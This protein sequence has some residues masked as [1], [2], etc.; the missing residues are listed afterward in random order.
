MLKEAELQK[1]IMKKIEDTKLLDLIVNKEIIYD[2]VDRRYKE[3][4]QPYFSINYLIREKYLDYGNMILKALDSELE[5]INGST[6]QNISIDDSE[7]LYP[8]II[9][10]NYNNNKYF[11]LELKRSSSAEREAVTEILGY[12][13]EIKNHLPFINNGDVPLIIVSTEFGDLLLHS[14]ASLLFD[15]I[16]V[17][18]LKPIINNDI[19]ENFMIMDVSAWTNLSVSSVDSMTFTGW[20][21]CLYGKDDKQISANEF[22]NDAIIAVDYL[23]NDANRIGSHGFC[24]VWESLDATGVCCTQQT[25]YFISVFT[26]NPYSIFYNDFNGE[27]QKDILSK[28][29]Y[30]TIEKTDSR[31]SPTYSNKMFDRNM[32][33]FLQDKY[34]PDYEMGNDFKMFKRYL[35]KHGI[36]L[37][38]DAWGEIGEFI[39]SLYINPVMKNMIK[40]QDGAYQNPETFFRLLDYLTNEYTFAKGLDICG[41]YLKFGIELGNLLNYLQI[42][43]EN[44]NNKYVQNLVTFA[45]WKLIS[46]VQ[47]V[48]FCFENAPHLKLDLGNIQESISNI[49]SFCEWFIKAL[50]NTLLEY[51]SFGIGLQYYF[52]FNRECDFKGV[53]EEYKKLYESYGKNVYYLFVDL[54]M[55]EFEKCDCEEV[56][57]VLENIC[58]NISSK[59]EIHEWNTISELI[60]V[61]SKYSYKNLR[62]KILNLEESKRIELLQEYFYE[63]LNTRKALSSNLHKNLDKN[64]LIIQAL[65][66]A[67]TD[68]LIKQLMEEKKKNINKAVLLH[69]DEN[70][71]ISIEISREK[72]EFLLYK[73]LKEGEV[74]FK[75]EHYGVE[76]L[77][78]VS[79]NDILNSIKNEC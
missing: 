20:T 19:F 55:E 24:I 68:W 11:I 46:A 25:D 34:R 74:I 41:E 62:S 12:K 76:I 35:S 8:D 59:L 75:I 49:E 54:F 60:A 15:N 18:C 78:A 10:Y 28:H 64:K 9:L 31:Y 77:T 21:I 1:Q 45:S 58:I 70:N 32:M 30:E 50:D 73:Q 2:N 56:S 37:Y 3:N 14:I 42:L 63:L 39:R 33:I 27:K 7:K 47:E 57:R 44:K 71:I 36:P 5:I 22:Y 67:D 52:M 48:G 79:I 40:K 69:I 66:C 16:P 23:K 26:V 29:I 65:K 13:L 17:L 61:L 43:M 72:H 53:K 6:I 4:F 51:H 38:C